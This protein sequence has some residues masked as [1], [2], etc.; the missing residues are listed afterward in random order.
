M[1]MP[2]PERS[3]ADL[4]TELSRDLSTLVRQEARL[5]RTELAERA[6]AAG[7][8]AAVIGLGAVLGLAALLSATAALILGLIQLNM[9]PWAAAAL[10][11]AVVGLVAGGLVR[12]RISQIRRRTHAPVETIESIKETAQWLKKE[13]VGTHAR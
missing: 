1:A 7:R 8:D 10:V 6:E 5:A 12:G 4:F 2:M 11:A 9:Q 13:T 3:I